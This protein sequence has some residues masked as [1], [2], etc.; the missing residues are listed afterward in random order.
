[1]VGVV[2]ILVHRAG[3]NTPRHDG[4]QQMIR[5]RAA[6]FDHS[7]LHGEPDTEF[8]RDDAPGAAGEANQSTPA[9]DQ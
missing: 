7:G 6:S 1:M 9:N 8:V 3:R 5:R 4:F 2:I